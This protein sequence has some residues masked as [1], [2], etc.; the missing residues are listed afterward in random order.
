L[1]HTM[2]NWSVKGLIEIGYEVKFD[3]YSFSLEPWRSSQP[4]VSVWLHF[5]AV[6]VV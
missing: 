2:N 4:W 6:S 5:G 3:K 1:P